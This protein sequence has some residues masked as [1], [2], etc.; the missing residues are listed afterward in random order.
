MSKRLENFVS[1]KLY[2]FFLTL[3]GGEVDANDKAGNQFN[4]KIL[5][6]GG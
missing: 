4:S 6:S 5:S 3:S 1:L 2:I